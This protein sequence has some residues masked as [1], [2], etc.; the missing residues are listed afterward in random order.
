MRR[1]AQYINNTCQQL[2]W[3]KHVINGRTP[4]YFYSQHASLLVC[5][6]PKT[7]STL[8]GAVVRAI[9]LF[10][11]NN[12]STI[13]QLGRNDIHKGLD[14]VRDQLITEEIIRT[15]SHVMVTRDPY[16]RLFSTFIDKYF[17]L[18]RLGRELA[19][20]VKRGFKESKGTY[21]GYDYT[22]QDF[23]DY[24]VYLAKTN[25]EVNEHMVPISQLCDVCRERYDLIGSQ[26]HL[27]EATEEILKLVSNVTNTRLD[28]IRKSIKSKQSSLLSLV[29]SHIFDYNNNRPDCPDKNAFSAKMW[30]TFQIQ[31]IVHAE[32]DFPTHVFSPFSFHEEE[33]RN[34]TSAILQEIRRKPLSQQEHKKQRLKY[35]SQAYRGIRWQTIVKI[36]HIYKLDILLF[37]YSMFPPSYPH[38]NDT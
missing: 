12:V 8:L 18:G 32:L 4:V 38:S 37:G 34:M 28:M 27:N 30:K 35:L 20:Y 13:F 6:A 22:F 19:L 29:S 21:C 15:R 25:L 17:L 11:E 10:N 3:T 5:K 31:G 36:Q 26:E 24:I 33:A 7:G 2:D 1:R 14:E 16:S 23:L 9:N